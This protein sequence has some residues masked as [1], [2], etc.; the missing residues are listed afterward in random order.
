MS[1]AE[2]LR[3]KIMQFVQ[4]ADEKYLKQLEAFISLQENESA[5]S[6]EHKRILEERLVQHEVAPHTGKSWDEL[7][8]ELSAKY[9]V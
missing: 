6:P 1:I 5:L 4:R 8:A 9:G 3:N 7:K 2:E